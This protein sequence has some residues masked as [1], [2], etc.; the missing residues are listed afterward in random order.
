VNRTA[1]YKL[2]YCGAVVLLL[3]DA[4]LAAILLGGGV[5]AWGAVVVLLLVPG[6]VQGHYYRELF[7]ARKLLNEGRYTESVP[8]GERFLTQ[9]RRS[10]WIKHLIWLSGTV[11]TPD[12]EAMTLNNL[13]AAHLELGHFDRA[14][15]A[16]EA[17]L[18]LDPAYAIAYYNLALLRA[19]QDDE[20]RAAGLLRRAQ[21]LG[22]RRT[23]VDQLIGQAQSLLARLEGSRSPAD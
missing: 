15:S 16:F 17:A 23:N 14:A 20:G 7:T 21:D 11:Y 2:L 10:P 18:A 8:H 3:A 5:Y 12:A 19:A 1:K 22:Y 13:G 4:V 9:V 6:R